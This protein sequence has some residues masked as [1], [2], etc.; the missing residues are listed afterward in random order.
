[1]LDPEPLIIVGSSVRAVAQSA[2]H[3]GFSPWCIDQFGDRDLIEIATDVRTVAEWPAGIESAFMDAPNANWLYTG[4]LENEPA[5]VARLLQSRQLLGCGPDVLRCIRDPRWL[6][7]TLVKASLPSLPVVVSTTDF[8]TT[9]SGDPVNP[10]AHSAEQWI[11]KPQAS[12]AGIRICD[13]EPDGA[14]PPDL[15]RYFLQKR[16]TGRSLSG[17][18]LGSEG[19]VQL[20]GMCE[21]LCRG[22]AARA[23]C[24]V[25]AGSLGPLS[26][27]DIPQRAFHQAQQIGSAISNWL[28]AEGT[29]FKGLFGIDFILD[30]NCGDLWTLEVN[31][32]YPA[33]AELYERAFGW[34]MIRWH[35][36]LCRRS[37]LP[38]ATYLKQVGAGEYSRKH[39]KLIVY[40]ERDF[41][42]PEIVPLVERLSQ[43][44]PAETNVEISDIPQLET[45]IRKDEPICTL[46]TAQENLSTCHEVLIA[47]SRELLAAIDATVD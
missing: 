41:V 37:T 42:T 40:A 6:A 46:V 21:Q 16:A 4:A 22:P 44:G 25:Y 30:E 32:R 26:S 10:T 12:A 39:G 36:D 38:S 47:A 19:A 8:E 29:H 5:L 15:D 24:F 33:S 18:Y 20:V 13:F 7:G 14:A 9:F 43:N 2:A 28:G 35:V 45:R 27:D 1:M 11:L 3:A 34:P 17:L 23:S 31:P